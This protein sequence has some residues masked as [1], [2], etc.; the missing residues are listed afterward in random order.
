MSIMN[1]NDK[2]TEHE[3][4]IANLLKKL[5][6]DLKRH[7]REFDRAGRQRDWGYPGDLAQIREYLTDA[8]NFLNSDPE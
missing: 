4:E 3:T 8:H 7:R 5:A 6:A 2:Y 1:A